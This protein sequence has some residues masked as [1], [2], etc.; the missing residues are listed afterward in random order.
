M[1]N[2]EIPL[3]NVRIMCTRVIADVV[4]KDFTELNINAIQIN[5]YIL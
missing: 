1:F 3:H 5:G 4:E 2:E